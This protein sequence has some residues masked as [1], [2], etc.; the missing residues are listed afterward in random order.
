MYLCIYVCF[1]NFFSSH[2]Y[3][4]IV[5]FR[6]LF[7]CRTQC[8]KHYEEVSSARKRI[9]CCWMMV[10]TTSREYSMIF[11]FVFQLHVTFSMLLLPKLLQ[12]QKYQALVNYSAIISETY[13]SVWLVGAASMLMISD[14]YSLLLAMCVAP[15][16]SFSSPVT[17]SSQHRF[18]ARLPK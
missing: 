15:C 17:A 9:W 1:W 3:L 8:A 4:V 18:K 16:V 12:L 10:L 2:T 11:V 6:V 5:H 14:S 7:F 13:P